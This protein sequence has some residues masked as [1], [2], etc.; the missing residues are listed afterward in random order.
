[1]TCHELGVVPPDFQAGE[2]LHCRLFAGMDP[3]HEL[4]PGGGLA[5][6]RYRQ[7]Q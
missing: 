6:A 1:M 3:F 5:M 2:Q 7:G 4:Q